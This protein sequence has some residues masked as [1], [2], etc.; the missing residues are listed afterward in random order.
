MMSSSIV[1]LF[2]SVY[3]PDGWGLERCYGQTQGSGAIQY[4]V[5]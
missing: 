1:L 4:A 3:I 2:I 5:K